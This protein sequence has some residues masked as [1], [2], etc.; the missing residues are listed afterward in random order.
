MMLLLVRFYLPLL[1]LLLFLPGALAYRVAPLGVTESEWTGGKEKFQDAVRKIY[2][3]V[4]GARAVKAN[5]QNAD[6]N[7]E[8]SQGGARNG[9]AQEVRPPASV[10]GIGERPPIHPPTDP[11]DRPIH[12]AIPVAVKPT[13]SNYKNVVVKSTRNTTPSPSSVATTTRKE[14]KGAPS[15]GDGQQHRNTFLRTTSKAVTSGEPVQSANEYAEDF[16]VDDS[17]S[18]ESTTSATASAEDTRT[19]P[20]PSTTTT[21]TTSTTTL[22][23]GQIPP[24]ATEEELNRVKMQEDQVEAAQKTTADTAQTLAEAERQTAKEE[25]DV[26]AATSSVDT[27]SESLSTAE[28][29]HATEHGGVD[30]AR[31]GL[32]DAEAERLA[33][34]RELAAATEIA[35]AAKEALRAAE[36]RLELAAKALEE[37]RAALRALEAD[38]GTQGA[39]ATSWAAKLAAAQAALEA[40]QEREAAAEAELERI[41]QEV[42]D[43]VLAEKSGATSSTTISSTLYCSTLLVL[44]LSSWVFL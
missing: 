24:G 37:Q 30:A 32:A 36:D 16:P 4:I 9:Q 1:Y 34:E 38:A 28:S 40:A 8:T 44:F 13:A 3:S 42:I 5:K 22:A 15:P 25:A 2:K 20:S 12:T 33:R 39:E 14:Q 35:T 7:A 10:A 17:T 23:P 19:T 11:H 27:A 6:E 21:T 26:V 41:K 18:A 29:A 43:R 31:T